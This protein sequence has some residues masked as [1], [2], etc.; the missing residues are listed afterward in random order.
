MKMDG[1]LSVRIKSLSRDR[2]QCFLPLILYSHRTFINTFFTP[3]SQMTVTEADETGDAWS[4]VSQFKTA[5][6]ASEWLKEFAIRKL[7]ETVA[8]YLVSF[9]SVTVKAFSHDE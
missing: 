1:F 5:K 4:H 2:K 3:F 9:I 8:L 7:Q 6:E